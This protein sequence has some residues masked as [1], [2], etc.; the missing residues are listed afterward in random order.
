M[1]EIRFFP[2]QAYEIEF[3]AEDIDYLFNRNWSYFSKKIV[4]TALGFITVLKCD[5]DAVV[6]MIC[7]CCGFS[8]FVFSGYNT[9]N[10]ADI[11]PKY[12]GSLFGVTNMIGTIPG[13]LAPQMVGI[14]TGV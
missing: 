11:A 1:T 6:A 5:R 2:L 3:K 4:A 10:H 14:I 9:P 8:G 12:A 13:F 7:I